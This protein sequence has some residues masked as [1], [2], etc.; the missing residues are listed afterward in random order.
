MLKLS[1]VF[2]FAYSNICFIVKY[3]NAFIWHQQNNFYLYK[4]K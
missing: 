2:F 3:L 1:L 4:L